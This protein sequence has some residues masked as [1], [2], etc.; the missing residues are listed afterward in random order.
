MAE[1]ST[2]RAPSISSSMTEAEVST[3]GDKAGSVSSTDGS[4]TKLKSPEDMDFNDDVERAGLL[5]A[6][7]QEEKAQPVVTDNSMRTAGIWMV[8]NTLATIGIVSLCDGRRAFILLIVCFT[9]LH[10]Q[11]TLLRPLLEARTTYL[12]RLSFLHNMAYSIHTFPAPIRDVRTKTSCDQRDHPPGNRHGHERHPSEPLPRILDSHILPSGA[13]PTYTYGGSHE[14]CALQVN[15]TSKCN[16]RLD[17][18]LCGCGN[19]LILRLSPNRGCEYQ[20]D[21]RPGSYFCLFRNIREFL[22][23]RL[24]LQLPQEAAD[25]QHATTLQ[26]GAPRCLHASVRHTFCGHF[27]CVDR[28]A[29]EQMDYDHDGRFPPVS[30]CNLWYSHQHRIR[31]WGP[32]DYEFLIVFSP[33]ALPA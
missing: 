28:S 22:I 30:T 19:G 3:E 15:A 8:V 29:W 26:P 4:F 14:L 21:K 31:N 16:L 13:D 10:E 23:H 33:A 5:P 18:G 7:Q 6:E 24:D 27:S 20:N 9:G 32:A 1:R 17:S 25:E 12:R 11:G 2:D